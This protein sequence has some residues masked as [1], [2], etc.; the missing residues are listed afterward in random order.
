MDLSDTPKDWQGEIRTAL[1]A[2]GLGSSDFDLNGHLPRPQQQP[3]R[4]AGVLVGFTDGAMGPEILLTKRASSLRH[5]PGQIAFPGGSKDPEDASLE[6]CALREAHEE[7]GLPP[8]NVSVIGRLPVHETV[9]G[10]AMTPV[11]GWLKGDFEPRLQPQE[12]TE[13]FRVPLRHLIE[14]RHYR[15]EG[16]RWRGARRQYYAVP[17][18]PYYIWGATARIL[19]GMADRL[20]R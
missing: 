2:E 3:L 14:P 13:L 7:I 12:V 20:A 17:W 4:Q 16:R 15:I 10:F 18:G 11:V 5:H 8:E 19:R 9:T 6:A 1:L